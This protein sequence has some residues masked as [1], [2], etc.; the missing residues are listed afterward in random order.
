MKKLYYLADALT[1]CEVIAGFILLGMTFTK[2]PAEYA[3]WAFVLG[4]LCDAFDG[5]CARRWSYPNDGKARWWRVHVKTIEHLSD[6]FLAIACMV[7]LFFGTSNPDIACCAVCLG[8]TIIVIC[9]SVELILIYVGEDILGVKLT[10]CLILVR[11][12]IYVFSGIAGG[13]LLLIFATSWPPVGK[14][15]ACGIGI[16]IGL[17][18]LIYKLDRALKP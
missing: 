18:L 6:I 15:G 16:S 1:L 12:W 2:M 14:L 3:I 5:P 7:Y 4:E 17:G 9:S 10:T 8:T 13:I 11:R